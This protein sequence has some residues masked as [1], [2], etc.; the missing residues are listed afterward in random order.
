[1]TNFYLSYPEALFQTLNSGDH[2]II[3]WNVYGGTYRMA[4]E[5]LSTHG[6]EFDFVE[7]LFLYFS[8][9]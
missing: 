8:E 5:V 6:F 2:V 3:G 9:N 7:L 4:V 1:M